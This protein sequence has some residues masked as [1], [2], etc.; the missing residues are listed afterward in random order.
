MD[1][2]WLAAGSGTSPHCGRCLVAW[3]RTGGHS[4]LVGVC[5]GTVR[6]REFI[7]ADHLN[8][9]TQ[10]LNHAMKKVFNG[11]KLAY[12]DRHLAQPGP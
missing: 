5:V 1:R 6:L 8:P 12:D 9:M 4:R 2:T 7:G 3:G 10:T 11:R